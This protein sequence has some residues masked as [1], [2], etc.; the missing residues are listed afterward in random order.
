[1]KIIE[2]TFQEF[3]KIE[4]PSDAIGGIIGKGGETIQ[5]MQADT[6]TKIS[7]GDEDENGNGIGRDLL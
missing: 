2:H 1:M 3:E 4:V 5:A 6:N 7:I